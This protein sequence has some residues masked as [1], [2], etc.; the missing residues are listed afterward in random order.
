MM[1]EKLDTMNDKSK[2]GGTRPGAGRKKGA[3][4]PQTIQKV[5]ALQN[6]RNRVAKNVDKLFNAQLDLAVG[7]KYLMVKRTEGT[8]KDRKSWTEIVTDPQMI[9]EYLDDTLENDDKH[10][11]FMTTKPA[12]NMAIDSLLDRTFGKAQSN[13]K[14]EGDSENPII[15]ILDKYGLEIK[16][17]NTQANPE[18]QV[19]NVRQTEETQS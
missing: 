3:L 17:V 12:S 11:Y 2:W 19:D 7:E 9:V 15:A 14:L 8:G 18:E 13:V 1:D 6:F 4:S 16:P 5:A 10:F